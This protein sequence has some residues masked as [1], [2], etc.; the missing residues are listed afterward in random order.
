AYPGETHSP[1]G[2]KYRHHHI[3]V[4]QVM[5]DRHIGKSGIIVMA[6]QITLGYAGSARSQVVVVRVIREYFHARLSSARRRQQR[7]VILS[8]AFTFSEADLQ[9]HL[10]QLRCHFSRYVPIA[11]FVEQS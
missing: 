7:L 9:P 5:A 10:R 2:W 4:G 8:G 6:E 1:I 3:L 11:T